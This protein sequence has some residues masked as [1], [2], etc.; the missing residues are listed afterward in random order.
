MLL[1][2]DPGSLAVSSSD[3]LGWRRGK[4]WVSATTAGSGEA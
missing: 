1:V 2:E 3:S 4:G